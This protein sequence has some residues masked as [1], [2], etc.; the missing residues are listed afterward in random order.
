MHCGLQPSIMLASRVPRPHPFSLVKAMCFTV[1]L[2]GLGTRAVLCPR[3]YAWEY[4]A[5]HSYTVQYE[6]QTRTQHS[7]LGS[8]RQFLLQARIH[9]L[10]RITCPS[11]PYHLFTTSE[12][13]LAD[14]SLALTSKRECQAFRLDVPI[15][16]VAPSF[17][18]SLSRNRLTCLIYKRCSDHARNCH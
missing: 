1:G 16:Y 5:V 6:T 18:M 12:P 8:A 13:D 17:D 10:L 2:A 11:P 9:C 15:T 3:R 14:D 4:Y 7:T